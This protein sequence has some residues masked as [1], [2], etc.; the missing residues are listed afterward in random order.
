MIAPPVNAP[1]VRVHDG[2]TFTAAFAAGQA[3]IRVAGID[4]PELANH[5]NDCGNLARDRARALLGRSATILVDLSQHDRY[6]RTIAYARLT[7]GRDLGAAL[8]TQGWAIA[9]YGGTRAASYQRAQAVAARAHRGIWGNAC[10]S[11]WRRP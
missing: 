1:I 11:T 10:T 8:I 6:G 9:R 4:A 2:D 7:D 5:P 3:S